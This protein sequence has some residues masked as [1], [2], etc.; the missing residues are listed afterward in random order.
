MP[1]AV[2][3]PAPVMHTTPP[4]RRKSA[5]RAA[6]VALMAKELAGG[7]KDAGACGSGPQAE[8]VA[9]VTTVPD[10]ALRTHAPTATQAPLATERHVLMSV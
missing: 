1:L 7:A 10:D 3:M 5:S 2:E 9:L 4:G 6:S 8:A